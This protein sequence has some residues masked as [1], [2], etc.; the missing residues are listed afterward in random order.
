MSLVPQ[1]SRSQ[2]DPGSVAVLPFRSEFEKMTDRNAAD[3]SLMQRLTWLLAF[4][5]A[6]YTFMMIIVLVVAIKTE[7]L[8]SEKWGR[9]LYFICLV[10]YVGIL[11]GAAWLRWRKHSHLAVHIHSQLVFDILLSTALIIATGGVDSG[12]LFLYSL[13]V[14]T[15]TLL[16]TRKG[17]ILY[18]ILATLTYLLV[19][20]W[21]YRGLLV[22]FGDGRALSEKELLW[23][24]LTHSSGVWVITFLAIFLG[25]QLRL[26]REV[27]SEIRAQFRLM[28][29][30]AG[31]MLQSLPAGVLTINTEGFVVFSNT[32]ANFLLTGES[33]SLAGKPILSVMPKLAQCLGADNPR[34]QFELRLGD[35][36]DPLFIGGNIAPLI[37][38]RGMKGKVVTF[39]NLTELRLL[40]EEMKHHD[41]LATLGRF[42]AGLA[43]EIRN[44][45]AAM[46]GCIELL[47][48]DDQLKQNIENFRMIQIIQRESDRL[49]NLVKDF[50][51]YARPKPP[52]LD[53]VRLGT[54]VESTVD[55][56]RMGM[57]TQVSFDLQIT[58][59]IPAFVDRHHMEQV[60]W[61]LIRNAV[62]ALTGDEAPDNPCIWV[63]VGRD[64]GKALLKIED[65]G[66]GIPD[67][68]RGKIFE[69]FY[70]TK[71]SGTGLGMAWVYQILRAQNG[72]IHIKKSTHDGAAMWLR[73]PLADGMI[74]ESQIDAFDFSAKDFS[75]SSKDI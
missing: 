4:R 37:G 32:I 70:T 50:L 44:P 28:E 6:L 59:D 62:E 39:E 22:P 38:I 66:P 46:S 33:G 35:D 69:P 49:S 55:A 54:L 42:S 7:G 9:S 20:V 24:F 30:M 11:F 5:V 23:G 43:H 25:E 27:V 15:A 3:D 64:R 21:Q 71:A 10:A 34:Q 8:I 16:L 72:T 61:N 47:S 74:T 26:S 67:E 45:L 60:I 13:L 75:K 19:A 56:I 2:T 1:S 63:W 58:E 17:T 73:M 57:E 68:H 65:N 53:M 40:Q 29:K 52:D 18:A 48:Q 14:L 51:N 36:Q 31:N 12:F 41:R